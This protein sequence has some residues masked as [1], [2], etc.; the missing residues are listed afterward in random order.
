[1]IIQRVT[2]EKPIHIAPE[3]EV[4]VRIIDARHCEVTIQH[5][6]IKVSTV[7]GCTLSKL[8]NEMWETV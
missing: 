2:F 1:M 6:Q 8:R 5:G 3:E 4:S 7:M